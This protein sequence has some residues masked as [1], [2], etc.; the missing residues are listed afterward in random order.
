MKLTLGC[1]NTQRLYLSHEQKLLLKQV[2]AQ[3]LELRHPEIPEAA[4]GL[5]GMLAADALL[6]ERNA[7]GILIGGLADAVWNKKRTEEELK[8][9]KDTDVL[10]L[11]PSFTL[12]KNFEKGIDWWLPKQASLTIRESYGNIEGN[13]EWWQNGNG[14]SLRYGIRVYGNPVAGL[15]LPSND[16]VIEMRVAEIMASIDVNRIEVADGFEEAL[17]KKIKKDIGEKTPSFL[18]NAFPKSILGIHNT[19]DFFLSVDSFSIDKVTA[20]HTYTEKKE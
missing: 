12:K 16:N 20:I 14:A 1:Y 15:Y 17:Y 10:V 11:D 9:H 7:T 18:Q 8:A 3:R 6:K 5:E 2:L 19:G 13:V 4:R